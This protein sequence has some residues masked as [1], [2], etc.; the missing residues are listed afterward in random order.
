MATAFPARSTFAHPSFV[1]HSTY[2]H[3]Y[4]SGETLRGASI[5]QNGSAHE[6]FLQTYIEEL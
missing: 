1:A 5:A 4:Q 3:A 2:Q 6:P